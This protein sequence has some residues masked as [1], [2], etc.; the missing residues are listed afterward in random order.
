MMKTKEHSLIKIISHHIP[1]EIIINKIIPYTYC[2]QPD[3]LLKDIKSSQDEKMKKYMDNLPEELKDI[4]AIQYV[5]N[6]HTLPLFWKRFYVINSKFTE[7]L[8]LFYWFDFMY[9]HKKIWLLLTPT[10][11]VEYIQHVQEYL[12]EDDIVNKM[13]Y[14]VDYRMFHLEM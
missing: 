3:S 1:I 2:V 11:R 4:Y 6:V 13:I 7:K 12:V 8:L 5:R 10:E 9:K 14:N